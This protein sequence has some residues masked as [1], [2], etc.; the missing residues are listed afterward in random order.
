VVPDDCAI[1]QDSEILLYMPEPTR[2]Q[3]LTRNVNSLL[4]EGPRATT[5]LISKAYLKAQN[6]QTTLEA[7]TDFVGLV[8]I[9]GDLQRLVKTNRNKMES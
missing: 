8:E 2:Y 7:Y 3:Y 9:S 4:D 5:K 6:S 1:L